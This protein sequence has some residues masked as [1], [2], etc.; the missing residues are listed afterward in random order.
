MAVCVCG[1]STDN[2]EV[3]ICDAHASC[4]APL[5]KGEKKKDDIVKRSVFPTKLAKREVDLPGFKTYLEKHS[6][7]PKGKWPTLLQGAWLCNLVSVNNLAH[8]VVSLESLV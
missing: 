2:A 3:G 8:I 4:P 6:R 5:A 1:V 7:K